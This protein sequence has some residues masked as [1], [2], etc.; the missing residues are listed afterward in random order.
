M[1]TPPVDK[2]VLRPSAH[3][4]PEA[5]SYRP[6]SPDVPSRCPISPPPRFQSLDN[7][8][9]F[10]DKPQTIPFSKMMVCF[11]ECPPLLCHL[12][13]HLLCHCLRKFK[14]KRNHHVRLNHTHTALTSAQAPPPGGK[15]L[16]KLQFIFLIPWKQEPRPPTPPLTTAHYK[17]KRSYD[18]LPT[19]P[20]NFLKPATH[21]VRA[22]WSFLSL[23]LILQ[24]SFFLIRL[25]AAT[26]LC[27]LETHHDRN[28]DLNW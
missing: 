4:S 3:A 17:K 5:S 20:S 26:L 16:L 1:P 7:S 9:V 18:V 21:L 23:F 10:N 15:H 12:V 25:R 22:H 27:L 6:T 19:D 2:L 24:I 28:L 11:R 14:H 8:D 13:P